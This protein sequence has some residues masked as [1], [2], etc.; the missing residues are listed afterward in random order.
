MAVLIHDFADIEWTRRRWLRKTAIAMV[1][2]AAFVLLP[3]AL[4]LAA[5]TLLGMLL[6]GITYPL[7]PHARWFVRELRACANEDGETRLAAVTV[8]NVR[9]VWGGVEFEQQWRGDGGRQW[10]PVQLSIMPGSKG[11][12]PN[13]NT[14]ARLVRTARVI[15]RG[16]GR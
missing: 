7:N 16:G 4:A 12:P 3:V 8:R 14:R 9:L 1:S 11:A 5:A 15:R 13:W 2:P 10:W 6:W